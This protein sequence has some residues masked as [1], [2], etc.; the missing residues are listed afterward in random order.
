MK[1]VPFRATGVRVSELSFGTSLFGGDADERESGRLYAAC[2]DRGINFFDTADAYS[3]GRSE[4]ILGRLIASEP[5]RTRHFVQVLQSDE[6]GHQRIAVRTD[7]ILRRR[8]R[9]A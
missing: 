8:S 2:R 3:G 9:P 7:A 4:E 6:R 1:Y 5:R